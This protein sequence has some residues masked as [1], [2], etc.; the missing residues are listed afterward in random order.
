MR[1]KY[2][3]LSMAVCCAAFLPSPCA[4]ALDYSIDAP[5]GREYYPATSYESSYGAE[6]NY[7]GDNISELVSTGPAY[8]LT[9][10]ASIGPM[11]KVRIPA[12]LP[13]GTGVNADYIAPEWESQAVYLPAAYTSAADMERSD[14]SIGTLSIPSLD[15]RMKVW[16][17]ATNSS[18]ARGLGHYSSTSGWD[19]NVGVCGHNR[20]ARYVIGSVKDLEAGDI[21]TY[22]TVYGSRSYEVTFVGIISN[23]D[24]SYLQPTSDNRITITTCL[25]G[26]PE[27]R[28]CVQAA[29][30]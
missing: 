26:Y 7:G 13:F 30:K 10:E 20:G 27:L 4:K 3:T 16:E 6:Y 21:I 11:E 15:I 12:G 19:G 9:Y 8:G 18:M 22:D 1:L 2:L 14:G 5:E 25:A 17:G 23:T 24:W 29:E 28:V